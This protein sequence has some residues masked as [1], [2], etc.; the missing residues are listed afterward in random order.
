MLQLS[1]LQFKTL[2]T[3][4]ND[5]QKEGV[6]ILIDGNVRSPLQIIQQFMHEDIRNYMRDYIFDDNGK[7]EALG[8]DYIGDRT[9][10][11]SS[12]DHK[13]CYD[14]FLERKRRQQDD[15]PDDDPTPFSGP[16]AFDLLK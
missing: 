4:L 16:D 10:D 14:A 15:C 9:G 1:H 2:Y 6:V 5:F 7:L 3:E 11:S 12:A 13:I 8:F